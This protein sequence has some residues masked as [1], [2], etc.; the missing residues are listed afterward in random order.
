LILNSRAGTEGST[1]SSLNCDLLAVRETVVIKPS[2]LNIVAQS[3]SNSTPVPF[4]SPY[5]PPSLGWALTR[6]QANGLAESITRQR[7]VAQHLHF[8]H[9]VRQA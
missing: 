1:V 7:E 5:T 3:L 2:R 6:L 9:T 8:T 4:L